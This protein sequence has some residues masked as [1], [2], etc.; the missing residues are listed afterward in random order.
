MQ[1]YDYQAGLPLEIFLSNCNVFKGKHPEV[2]KA[3]LKALNIQYT[4]KA[5]KVT[6][7][8]FLNMSAIMTHF[9]AAADES[10]DFWM[11]VSKF[12]F[13]YVFL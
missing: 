11:R 6:L 4:L 3:I 1:E 8:E 12:Y 13:V 10:L 7:H 2:V 9:T 5:C